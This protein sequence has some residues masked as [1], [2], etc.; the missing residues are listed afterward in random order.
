LEE[1]LDRPDLVRVFANRATRL[2]GGM[3]RSG[4]GKVIPNLER[5]KERLLNFDVVGIVEHFNDSLELF[6]YVFDFPPV[7]TERNL[8]ISPNREARSTISDKTLERI[9]EVEW[10]DIELYKLGAKVFNEQCAKMRQEMSGRKI[11]TSK[12]TRVDS[13]RVDFSRVDPG[14][15]WHVGERYPKYGVVRWTG[16]ET[17]SNIRLPLTQEHS[18]TVRF[19]VLRS[20]AKDILESLTMEVNGHNIPLRKQPGK[21]V[22]AVFNG[23]V[24]KEILT[25]QTMAEFSFK[26]NRTAPL[27]K[28]A[29]LIGRIQRIFK[30]QTQGPDLRF[31]G[32]LFNWLEVTA[33]K[34]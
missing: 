1:F 14:S 31:G 11:K 2:I 20:A 34:D 17:A 29:S 3:D 23:N 32:L 22:G 4:A 7:R 9:A 18:Y 19:G 25:N 26:V 5:A 27:G 10:A 28:V 12:V 16:P 13:A 33:N 6:C 8:N 15:G 24:P 21:W 30:S